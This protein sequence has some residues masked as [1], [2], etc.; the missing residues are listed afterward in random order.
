MLSSDFHDGNLLSISTQDNALAL[1]IS[2]NEKLTKIT[3]KELERLRVS[4]FKE[5]NII[6]AASIYCGVSEQCSEE[7]Y[8]LLLKYVYDLSDATLENDKKISLFLDRKI[9]ALKE[10]DILILEIEPSYGAYMV[11]IGKAVSEE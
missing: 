3:L 10:R 1:Y 2:L 6:N 11:A 5:G 9:E 4:D 7:R 8:T